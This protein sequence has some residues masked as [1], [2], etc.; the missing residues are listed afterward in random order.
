[1][2]TGR[3]HTAADS[4]E[5]WQSVVWNEIKHLNNNNNNNNNNI[6]QCTKESTLFC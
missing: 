4:A 3:Q 5:L 1:M 2:V 6:A